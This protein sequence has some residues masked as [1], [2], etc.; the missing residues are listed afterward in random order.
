[1]F[2]SSFVIIILLVTAALA[3]C[4][5]GPKDAEEEKSFEAATEG[6][7][8]TQGFLDLYTKPDEAKILALFP[9]PAADGTLLRAIH[10]T[11][12]TSGLGSNPIGL[13]RGWGNSGQVVRFRRIGGKVVAEVE[14]HR[15]R[16]TA[17]AR[18]EK[19]A[20]RDS[21]ARSFLWSA[22]VEAVSGD[23][24]ILV[25]L[26]GL[27]TTDVLNLA[28]RLTEEKG[29]AF[30]PNAELSMPEAGAAMAFPD[31][32]ELDAHLTFTSAEPGPEVQATAPWPN[33]VTLTVHHSF[34][35]L[36]PP[37]YQAR[38][39]DPRV[40]AFTLDYYDYSAPLKAQVLQRDVTRH[41]LERGEPGNPEGGVKEPIVFY[42]DPGAPEQIRKALIEGASWWAEAFEAAGFPGG[43]RVELLPE[44]AHP[45]DIRYNVIQWVH[46]Q[47]RGWSYGGGVIDPRTGEF[48]KGHVILGSQR[49]RQDRMI[50]EG[51]AG[52]GKSGTGAPDDPVELSL[53]RIRQL[54]A[55]EVGHALGI[56][57]NF[58]ASATGRASV[59]DYPAP[60]VVAREDGTLDF[61]R[62]YDTGIG[63]WDK[64]AV[65][66]LYG[67]FDPETEEAELNRIVAE[68]RQAGLL[69]IADRHGR[70]VGTSH[71]LAAIW[72]NGN[73]PVAELA[74]V[75]EVRRIA[76]EN[77]SESV[78]AEGR[79]N[80]ALREAI[81]PIYLYHRYQLNAA[82]KS[83]GGMAFRYGKNGRDDPHTDIVPPARQRRALMALLET[84]D[85]AALDIPDR[86]L[87]MMEPDAFGFGEPGKSETLASRS[88]PAFDLAAAVETAA[89]LTFAAL[90]DPERVERLAQ[91]HARD[92]G[93]PS[94][95]QVLDS[96]EAAIFA[97]DTDG[98]RGEIARAVRGRYV[99]ALMELEGKAVS[100]SVH[101]VLRARLKSLQQRFAQ[102]DGLP[103]PEAAHRALLAS[104]IEAHLNRPAPER[105]PPVAG[106]ETPPGSPIGARESCWH[107]E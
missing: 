63:E 82:A 9:A 55:H 5:D 34:V 88:A 67:A 60:W 72:D 105:E 45:L 58:A 54:A 81:V 78:L 64:V 25:D 74:N 53:A 10:A 39:A 96:V 57:H 33:A 17:D 43:F 42:V 51:L 95:G 18:L 52:A 100:Q 3:A 94:L 101:A 40:G 79:P 90:L 99:F 7:T 98:R 23:G 46:R 83:L 73:D 84:L 21:F 50:F 1:M 12:L 2:R 37:G 20:V 31:N 27:L 86:I 8:R 66:W 62:A 29:E 6:Y 87:T 77:F 44:E 47:T 49:V 16:A 35:R 59:M 76:L 80:A 38:K 48:I 28:R 68:A 41:R 85:P 24:R 106:P 104:R 89:D 11:R 4:T 91:F 92:P 32:V 70:G 97:S 75:M 71:P 26:S 65:K 36:P 102:A 61:S 103:P 19:Q 93:M 15:Y 13:D 107:C 69:Y 56:G 30:T 14:N 22:P